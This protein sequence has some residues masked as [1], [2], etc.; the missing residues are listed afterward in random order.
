MNHTDTLKNDR[1][2]IID[3]NPAI[4]EDIRKILGGRREHNEAF[5]SD[6]ALLFDD[7]IPEFEQARFEI[8][9]AY[10]GRKDWRR[11]SRRSKPAAPMPWPSWMCACRPAGT[12]SRPSAASGKRIRTCK[13]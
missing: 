5:D 13:W 11:C 7:A 3:D 2:L 10:Q 6:K 12:A 8:D 4:H 1:I 9:S